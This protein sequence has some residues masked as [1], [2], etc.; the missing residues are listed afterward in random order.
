MA[1]VMTTYVKIVN[2]NEETFLKFSDLFKT[3][4]DNSSYVELVNHFNKLFDEKFSEPD[5]VMNR[6]WMEQNIGSKWITVEFG[7]DGYTPE[8]D[9]IIESA[10]SVPT[11]YIQKVVEVLNRIN[12]D[13]VAYG[14]YEDEGFSPI[15][16]FVYGYDYDDIEDYDEEV[17]F[18]E[19]MN[20]DEYHE[21]TYDELYSLRDSLYNSYLEAKKEREE[22]DRN[23]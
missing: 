2:L 11:E 22:D 8:V 14:T 4:N 20:D 18:D 15:G 17:D 13:I 7:D 3:E 16:A 19:M 5:N 6:E 10:W 9:V 12:K 21:K 1:N 23:G